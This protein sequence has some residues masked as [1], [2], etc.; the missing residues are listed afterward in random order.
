[1]IAVSDALKKAIIDLNVKEKQVTVIP[2]GVDLRKFF[3]VPKQETRR[4]LNL[5]LNAR[6]VLFVGSLIPIKGVDLLIKGLKILVEEFNER[7]LYLVIVGGG[8][9]QKPLETLVNSLHLDQYVRM[10]GIV[11]HDELPL[12]YSCADVFCLVS[13]R[14]GWP[15]VLLEAMA[16]GVP[17]VATA[18]G[19]IPEV[20]GSNR[21]G[22]LTE[23]NERSIAEA[24]RNALRTDW[25]AEDLREFAEKHTW[26]ATGE[27]VWQIY[28]TILTEEMG[29]RGV[30]VNSVSKLAG[31]TSKGIKQSNLL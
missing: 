31:A 18:V 25:R 17:V 23:R 12:W 1:V 28:E 21:L 30:R 8:N 7:K 10:P 3:R 9:L 2:N 15:C 24:I 22:Y 5:P 20:I 14:E 4:R 6:V 27:A 11:P 29:S 19:G 26:E 13:S 16:C